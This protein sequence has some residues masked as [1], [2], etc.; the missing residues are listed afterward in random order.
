MATHVLL[1]GG[2]SGSG[3]T[4]AASELHA[5]LARED[6]RHAVIEGDYLDLAHPTP[7]EHHLA[8]RNLAAVWANY[9]ELGYERLIF[10]NT[11]APLQAAE[12]AAAMGDDP[13]V[14]AVVLSASNDT[15]YARLAG[16]E[17][18]AELWSTCD[19]A[20]R[21]PPGWTRNARLRSSEST[22]MAGPAP[23]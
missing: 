13:V 10:S 4:Q 7:W 8:E 11:I 21:R 16:R 12:L 14:T 1:I 20:R 19:A 3:K 6:V 15:V 18:G 2:R 23:R 9:R 5:L 17:S 22:P